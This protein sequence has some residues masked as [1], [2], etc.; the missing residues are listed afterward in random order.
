M[1]FW[2]DVKEFQEI[3]R[4]STRTLM[5]NLRNLLCT[6]AR[7]TRISASP[8]SSKIRNFHQSTKFFSEPAE[9][10]WF[11][12]TSISSPTGPSKA[13]RLATAPIPLPPPTSLPLELHPLYSNLSISPFLDRTKT[14]FINAR[15]AD[16]ESS[17]CDWIVICTLKQGREGGL[18]GA[19]EGVRSFVSWSAIRSCTRY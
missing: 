10:P 11:V 17:W 13:P 5:S 1:T 18:R 16:P 6:C 15:E 2:S 4:S 7:S 9:I 12:D 19:I 14:T 3:S 8:I